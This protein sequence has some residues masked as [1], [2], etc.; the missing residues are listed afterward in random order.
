MTA[1]PFS[2]LPEE[3]YDRA[4]EQVLLQLAQRKAA[5]GMDERI[6]GQGIYWEQYEPEGGSDRMIF[7]SHGFTESTLEYAEMTWYFLQAG[8]GVF[9][10][11]HM[12]HGRSYRL[13][14]ETW[15]T[16][17]VCFD[18]YVQ[19][20]RHL[21]T[22][23]V[24]PRSQGKQRYLFGHSMGGAI[25]ILYLEQYHGDFKKAILSAPMVM[26]AAGGFPVSL[27]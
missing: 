18:D 6:P 16:H 10:C 22:Q 26:P 19:D 25:A 13:L 4:M 2:L 11:D 15:L 23:E 1:L 20:L 8:Y 14:K 7:I 24:L 5:S 21:V 3:D 27:G 17:A 12:G 9:L